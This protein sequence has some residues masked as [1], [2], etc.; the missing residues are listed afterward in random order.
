MKE[1]TEEKENLPSHTGM[2]S[3]D[4]RSESCGS[5]SCQNMFISNYNERFRKSFNELNQK[6]ESS[7]TRKFIS[8][9]ICEH[10]NNLIKE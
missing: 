9:N 5:R 7:S 3:E 1:T 10:V 4:G 8:N 2:L 6:E